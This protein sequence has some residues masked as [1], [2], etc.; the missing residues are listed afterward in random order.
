MWQGTNEWDEGMLRC[1]MF[2]WDVDEVLKIK[3][4]LNRG[5]DCV[6]WQNEKSGIFTVRSAYM[7]AIKTA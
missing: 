4:P 6:A 3:L 1:Y 2:P 7:L 5:P